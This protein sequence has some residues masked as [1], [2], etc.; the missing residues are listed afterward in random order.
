MYRTI[1]FWVL[2]AIS[3]PGLFA[4]TTQGLISGSVVNSVS[5]RP[6][7]GT[8]I[9]FAS[10]T[11][12]AS[13]Q[14]KTD[15]AGFFFLP[16]L[17]PGTYT[18]TAT[19]NGYQTQQLQQL[20]LTVAGRIQIDFKLRP[21]NDVWE[22]G[23][24]RSVFLPGSKT[25]V[26]FYGPDVD[27]SRSGSFE[28]QQGRRGTLDTSVSYVID[29]AQIGDLPLLGRDVYTMLVSLPGVGANNGTARGLGITVAGQRP[30]ASNF[31][32][33][34]VENDNYLITGPLTAVAPEA[35]QEY[36]IS[37]NNYS[38]EYGR[39]SGFIANA[40]TRAGSNV[41]HGIGYEYLKNEV[42]NAADF[43]DNL[44]GF[45]RRHDKENQFGYQVGGPVLR[46]R[47]FFSS[48]L[49]ELIS[50]SQQNPQTFILPTTNFI[51]AL[52]LPADR[53]SR[54]LLEKYPHP[55]I[56]ATALTAPYVTA[57][58]VVVDRLLALERGDYS[59]RGGRDHLMGRL[60]LVRVSEPDFFWNP[61]PDFIAGL[62]QHTT[63]AM[64]GWTHTWTPRLT[65][66]LKAS[67]SDDNLWWDRPHPEI[68]TLASFDG[69]LLPASNLFYAYRN[70]NRSPEI[71]YSTVWT[72]NRHVVTAG[73]GLLFRFNS[74]YLT[75][76]RDGEYI[77]GTAASFA[78]DRPAEFRAMIN[79]LSPTPV[80]PDYNRSYSYAQNYFF[81]QDSFRVSSRL[82]LNYG[83]RYERY[84]APQN[85]GGV[86]DAE[87]VF[88]SGSDF[89]TRLAAAS[90]VLPAR[91]NQPIFG[92]DNGDWAP[93]A[94]FSWDPLGKGRTVVRGGF[95]LFY[96]R[97]F[98][99]LWQNERNN[100]NVLPE[101]FLSGGVTNYLR[102]ISSVLP[103]FANQSAV[104]DFPN[105]TVMD[106]RLRNGYTETFFLGAEQAVSDSLTISVTGTGALGHRLLTTDIV[107]RQYTASDGN[108]TR[109]NLS[110]PDISWRSSQ[111]QSKYA[112]MTALAKY[113]RRTL[114]LQAAYT[115]SHSIDNQ[116]D[117]LV[118]DFF[119]LDFTKIGS[120]TASG[121]I[122]AFNRQFDSNAD[123]GNSDF[124]Q[125][126]NLFLIGVWQ[127]EGTRL[128]TKG[129]QISSMAAFRSGLPYS[130]FG[131]STD[132]IPT[133]G[134]FE[135]RTA[136]LLNPGIAVLSQ[137][138][139]APGGVILLNRSAFSSPGQD[140]AGNI[141]RN[142]FGG[143]G[144]W[145][146]DLSL[147]RSFSVPRLREGTRI[148]VRADAFNI[149]NHAN[150]NN[151]DN[152]LVD[153]NFGL[154]TY[155]RAGTASGFPAV[156][157]VNETARQV[158]L[159]V[160]F[161]F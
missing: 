12:A 14:Y 50:H 156:S 112:A 95:G 82:T 62:K 47:L 48:A 157:P 105:L 155:G 124:D 150:L 102:P 18:I 61:Y 145:N 37:T 5:G 34:G 84:G 89:N 9:T 106:P 87:L 134:I 28:G 149:V 80:Q 22:A 99:N 25:I 36:R 42:L 93:R 58:P 49:E 128:L 29:P 40:V 122:S 107:N 13:G 142:A 144:L 71:I 39:T 33:D 115:W 72:R 121:Q 161:E 143:P 59:A 151:P 129:W 24:F 51:P 15:E 103:S 27:T 108:A 86:K 2:A 152:Y 120:G 97:P 135:N 21:L 118:G 138:V 53:L 16:L 127:S 32:L 77:F 139:P 38:A 3:I 35:V 154:A 130:V 123:R 7:S 160:R 100:G 75:A 67:Y 54:Q 81:V 4:Q 159:L 56:V 125:R 92:A 1:G 137:P 30:S 19:A 70:H 65:S 114:Q 68:P 57:P 147:A 158:Q 64:L 119:N 131:A 26:T 111:G 133:A 17:S 91:G 63:G 79:R 104:S 148:T 96:D 31:L 146:I 20:E 41:F 90:L 98:D 83:L 74:G 66:E 23:Q 113:S 140:Q 43:A 6:V 132:T 8:S 101:Y 85:T 136:N 10:T 44:V 109:P 11:L 76:G 153:A 116:S 117:P 78:L 141:G 52:Q 88:G 60:A 69:T 126:H 45:G 55:V 46:D 73:A 94:G 110:F